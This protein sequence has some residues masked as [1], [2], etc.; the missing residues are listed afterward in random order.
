VERLATFPIR[1]R[2]EPFRQEHKD[3]AAALQETLETVVFHVA[4]H[5][6]KTTG[7]SRLALA[8]GIAHNCTLSGK[9]LMSNLFEDVFVQPAS[10]DAGCAI[11]AALCV[12]QSLG[13]SPRPARLSSIYWGP[14]IAG[15]EE[16]ILSQWRPFVAWERTSDISHRTATLLAEGGVIGWVQ[17]RSEFG[18]RALG[19]RSI[20]ADPRP[21]A[22]KDRINHMVKKREG[23][24]P[25]A[26]SV[27]EEALHEY[28]DVPSHVDAIPFMTFVVPVRE[29][30]R[31]RLAA[32]THVD[33]TARVQTVSRDSNPAYWSLLRAFEA[34]TGVGVL[35]NTSLNNN[36]EPIVDSVE[37]AMVSY[38]TT[39]IDV[40]AIGDY[41][42]TR[43]P[44]WRERIGTLRL[45]LPR[46]CR[47]TS[48]RYFDGE[49]WR[50]Q[51]SVEDLIRKSERIV[52]REVFAVLAA[53]DGEKTIDEAAG[54]A[55][56]V[57]ASRPSVIAELFELW[58]E[59]VVRLS[60]QRSVECLEP[61]AMAMA[62]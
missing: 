6:A 50:D 25:F 36:S 35:L 2:G 29:E 22:N 23:Y 43:Q 8:G 16:R 37:D 7:L 48:K 20:L 59:R 51:W 4:R 55:A 15:A 47:L 26:P 42:V 44:G 52:T 33:G 30:Q 10:H 31:A 45:T 49:R 27:L 38:L 19:N 5:Y 17:G 41:W 60:P 62:V 14:D 39:S 1:R 13:D 34:Q 28:F 3:L 12:G 54:A 40:M 61:E 32:V 9:L 11:G 46:H 57:E 21:A 18:P 53:A 56:V 58:S 24:R